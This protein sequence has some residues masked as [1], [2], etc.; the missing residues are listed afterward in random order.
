MLRSLSGRHGRDEGM[1]MKIYV[2]FYVQQNQKS[3]WLIFSNEDKAKRFM[4]N[5]PECYM[6]IWETVE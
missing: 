5:H 2:M 6:E 4:V 3:I 1:Q